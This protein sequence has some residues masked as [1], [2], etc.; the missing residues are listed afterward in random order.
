MQTSYTAAV[1]KM[2]VRRC[3]VS[4]SFFLV[5]LSV[6]KKGKKE[7]QHILDSEMRGQEVG[8]AIHTH[9]SFLLSILIRLESNPDGSFRPEVL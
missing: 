6:E 2:N 7:K 3:N 9:L 5:L 4:A 8:H 1:K